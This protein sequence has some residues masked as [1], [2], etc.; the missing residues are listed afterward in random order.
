[1]IA[2]CLLRAIGKW[3]HARFL[4]PSRNIG[5][6]PQ[7]FSRTTGAC[8]DETIVKTKKKIAA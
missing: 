8:P 2:S 6:P 4:L 7:A 3:T 5:I 1:M